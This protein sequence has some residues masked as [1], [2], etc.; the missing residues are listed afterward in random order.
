MSN[1]AENLALFPIGKGGRPRIFAVDAGSHIYA[2][3]LVSQLD[4]TSMLV[5]GST[6]ASG[7]AIGISTHEQDATSGSDADKLC[8][9]VTDV[10]VEMDNAAA[11]HA[12]SAATAFGSVVYMQNDHTISADSNTGAYFAAGTFVGMSEAGRVQFYIPMRRADTDPLESDLSTT[13]G[14]GLIGILDSGT[15]TAQTT[16]ETALAELYQNL[17]TTKGF[18]DIPLSSWREVSSAG[19]VGD[20]AANGGIL[21]SDTTPILGAE[22]TSEAMAIKWAAA[23]ADIVQCA[24]SLPQ[25]LDDTADATLDLWVLTDN[26]GGGGIEAATFSVLTSFNNA[27]QATDAA[28]DSVPATTVHKVTATID[29]GD[30]P[31]GAAFVNIQLVPGTHANDPTHLL[32]ARLNYKRKLLTS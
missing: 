11:P 3:T 4:A 30:I 6:A 31:T 5:P 23:N 24:F 15:F 29:A 19:A 14:A 26:A 12:C 13:A 21:A 32:A 7:P 18:I 25:D 16:V 20:I 9:V 27:S 2:G 28:T 22:A 17:F 1:S 8:A 10:V